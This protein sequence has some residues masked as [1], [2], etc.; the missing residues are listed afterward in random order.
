MQIDIAGREYGTWTVADPTGSI[1]GVDLSIDG[2]V[3]W[4]ALAQVGVTTSWRGL[5]AGPSA[6]SNPGGTVVVPSGRTKTKI[7]ATG[8]PEIIIRPTGPIDVS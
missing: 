6:T 5:I 7:R 2:G 4:T 1:T 8:L 3:T